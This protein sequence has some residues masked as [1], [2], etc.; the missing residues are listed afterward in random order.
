MEEKRGKRRR[1]VSGVVVSN[2]MDKTVV[3]LV[4]KL[5][6][7][8]KYGRVIKTKKRF[9]AHDEKNE[10]RM[11][12]KVRITECRPLSKQKRWRLIS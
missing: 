2:S 10:A 7:H 6:R 12:D 9:K 1:I 5:V 3:V 11:G 8:S 4:S